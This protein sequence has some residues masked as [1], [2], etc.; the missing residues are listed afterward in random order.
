MTTTELPPNFPA[1]SPAAKHWAIHPGLV[2]LNHGSFGACPPA[3]LDAQRGYLDL[4]ERDTV[5]FF[6]QLASPMLDRSRA[7]I[8]PLL[9]CDAADLVFVPNATQGVQA[10]LHNMG[11]A[12]GDELLIT[13]HEYPA[14]THN[15]RAACER[16]GATLVTAA[17]P[18]P[19]PDADALVEAVLSRVTDRTKACMISGVTSPSAI[20]MPLD[21]LCPSLRARGVE[22]LLDAAH[23]VG[24]APHHLERWDV[25]WATGNAHKW[26]CSP[27]GSAWLYVRPDLQP[28]FRPPVLSNSAPTRDRVAQLAG[29][30]AFHVEFD[31]V[32][33]RDITPFLAIADAAEFLAGVAGSVEAYMDHNRDLALA[34]R[35]TICQH[36]GLEPPVPDACTGAIAAIGLDTDRPAGDLKRALY[37]RWRIQVPVWERRDAP[38]GMIGVGDTPVLRV[39]AN[40]YNSPAQY[41]YLA[42][43]LATELA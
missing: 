24:F 14:C 30:S 9:G 16:S 7:A 3:V 17:L 26:L 39:S 36:L 25:A 1:P 41:E 12:P 32:G 27:K 15:C 38:E 31:Y 34:G 22:V 4:M 42:E 18:W 35:A 6:E 5:T 28:A 8:A 11:L 10:A 13:S 29:R 20:A 2:P 43:A 23:G 19:V 40:F 37:D 33:T 21:E